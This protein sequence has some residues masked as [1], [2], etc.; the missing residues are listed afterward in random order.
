[1]YRPLPKQLGYDPDDKSTDIETPAG[2]VNVA[3]AAVLEFRHHDKS[4]QLG[5]QAQGPYSDWTHFRPVNMPTSIPVRLPTIHPIDP[6]H[7]QPLIYVDSA[8]NFVMQMFTAAQWC[9]VTPFALSSR[10]HSRSVAEKLPPAAYG[11]AQH[12]TQAEELVQLS[13]GPIDQQKMMVEYW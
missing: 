5:D 10:D 12:R 1:V 9:Y 6:S 8:G 7:W 2:I 13:A 3:C 4:N 11:S